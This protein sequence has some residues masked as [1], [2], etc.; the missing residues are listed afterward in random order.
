MSPTSRILL[1]GLLL[2]FAA[3]QCRATASSEPDGGTSP[4]AQWPDCG[5]CGIDFDRVRSPLF[6]YAYAMGAE[7]AWA[8]AERNL[9]S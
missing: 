3:A 9:S 6:E 2:M 1:T 8:N 5:G 7:G 4:H